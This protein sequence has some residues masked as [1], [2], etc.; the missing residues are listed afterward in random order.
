M[1][2]VGS[3]LV[4]RSSNFFW[5]RAFY[6]A[7]ASPQSVEYTLPFLVELDPVTTKFNFPVR[8][9]RIA[10]NFLQVLVMFLVCCQRVEVG[11]FVNALQE[12]TS[13]AFR[14][15]LSTVTKQVASKSPVRGSGRPPASITSTTY[16][17]Y[18]LHT[19]DGWTFFRNVCITEQLYMMPTPKTES[20]SSVFLR[21]LKLVILA[22]SSASITVGCIRGKNVFSLPHVAQTICFKLPFRR[23][24]GFE[25][26]IQTVMFKGSKQIYVNW[27]HHSSD[28]RKTLL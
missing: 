21:N 23:A 20:T 18:S 28:G 12:D 22:V 11:C 2:W 15:K 14:V 6:V 3:S 8:R 13:S 7:T 19:E 16:W 10:A 9:F 24:R 26:Q 25:H 27:Q 17:P 4:D 1:E 5:S